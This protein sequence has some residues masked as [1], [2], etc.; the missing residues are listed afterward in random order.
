MADGLRDRPWQGL[1]AHVMFL[2]SH[3]CC[4]SSYTS[5]GLQAIDEIVPTLLH[6]LEDD[7]TSDTT[8]DGLTKIL[9]VRTSAVLPH[10]LPKLVH[11]PL[12]AFHVHSLGALAKVASPCLNFHLGTMLPALLSTMGDEDKEVQAS[13]KEVTEIMVLVIDEK[14]VESLI[15]ELVKG[16]NDS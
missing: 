3:I 4:E 13:S 7:K 2:A 12:Y 6:A 5:V 9:S 1:A 16:V 10:I 8:L 15:S 11:L 14:G